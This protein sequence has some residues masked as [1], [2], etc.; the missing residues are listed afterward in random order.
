MKGNKH[1]STSNVDKHSS[2]KERGEYK[3]EEILD[4]HLKDNLFKVHCMY[5]YPNEI[6]I[7]KWCLALCDYIWIPVVMKTKVKF[8]SNFQK[9]NINLESMTRKEI[10]FL[11]ENSPPRN[12]MILYKEV[13]IKRES[14]SKINIPCWMEKRDSYLF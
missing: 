14:I 12:L 13:E 11:K 7:S 5:V 1:A 10:N 2:K 9:I 8:F 4:E 6:I 3:L